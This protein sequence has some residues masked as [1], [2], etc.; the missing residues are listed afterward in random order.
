VIASQG[1]VNPRLTAWCGSAPLLMMPCACAA[2]FEQCRQDNGGSMRYGYAGY[3]MFGDSQDY[4]AQVE[5][6]KAA[7]CEQIFSDREDWGPV[8]SE[9][10]SP[11][12]AKLLKALQP[13]DVVTVTELDRLGPDE[14]Y[15]VD[16]FDKLDFRGCEFVSLDGEWNLDRRITG[17]EIENMADADHRSVKPTIMRVFWWSFFLVPLFTGILHY[18]WLP[19][20]FY[21]EKRHILLGSHEVCLSSG[22]CGDVNDAWRDKKSGEIFTPADFADHRKEEAVRLAVISFAYGLIGCFGFGYFFR[23]ENEHGSFFK[24]FGMAVCA[25]LAVALFNFAMNWR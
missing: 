3:S 16:I 13:G 5:R 6:L 23:N 10:T 20:E 2:V 17:N 9:A 12:L 1:F 11:E 18:Q 4:A 25:N 14:D 8:G 22:Q 7:G 15:W 24:Y 21:D 19:N